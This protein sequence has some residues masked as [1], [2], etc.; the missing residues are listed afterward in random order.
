[1]VVGLGGLDGWFFGLKKT[2]G[3]PGK[4][5]SGEVTGPRVGMFV[6][7]PWSEVVESEWSNFTTFQPGRFHQIQG[8]KLCF[9]STTLNQ[10]PTV[11]WVCFQMTISAPF[12]T[13]DFPTV[14]SKPHQDTAFWSSVPQVHSLKNFIDID[15]WR[16]LQRE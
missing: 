16:W 9:Q 2:I 6:D 7:Q 12:G 1:M 10:M 14:I 11:R 15:F 8:P 13:V 3:F 5:F 4:S